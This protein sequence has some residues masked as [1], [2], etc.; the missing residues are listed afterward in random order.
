VLNYEWSE[1]LDYDESSVFFV[2]PHKN[3]PPTYSKLTVSKLHN[4]CFKQIVKFRQF[5]I[6]SFHK[7]S[8]SHPP[9]TVYSII[10]TP[11]ALIAL[12]QIGHGLLMTG[13]PS[14]SYLSTVSL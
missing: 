9:F 12:A 14:E 7:I 5:H 11:Y 13:L 2:F 1:I 8:V 6:L 4:V 3:I 10:F